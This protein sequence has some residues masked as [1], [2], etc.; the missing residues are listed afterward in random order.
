[1]F[2][3]PTTI[4]LVIDFLLSIMQLNTNPVSRA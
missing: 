2:L 4:V 1:M 3:V